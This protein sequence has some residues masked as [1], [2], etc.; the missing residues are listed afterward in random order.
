MF[1]NA[2]ERKRTCGR[3]RELQE[4]PFGELSGETGDVR[5]SIT[6][7]PEG[8]LV[9]S[10][11]EGPFFYTRKN[12]LQEDTPL[13]RIR[14]AAELLQTYDCPRE[15]TDDASCN[16]RMEIPKTLRGNP[17]GLCSFFPE[18]D[19]CPQPE[20]RLPIHRLLK[21]SPKK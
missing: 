15:M 2:I 14:H 6:I 13:S 17:E 4:I 5:T 3:F 10:V 11:R 8:Y 19:P 16:R 18:R 12:P 21:N 7:L 1:M 20:A 9:R